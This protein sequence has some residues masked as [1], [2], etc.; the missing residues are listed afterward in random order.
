VVVLM[1]VPSVSIELVVSPDRVHR[2]EDV[3]VIARIRNVGRAA[4]SL[5]PTLLCAGLALELRSFSGERMVLGSSSRWIEASD[6]APH[7]EL[8]PGQSMSL[9]YIRPFAGR[10]PVG[11]YQVRLVS[12]GAGAGAPAFESTWV[13]F[14][15]AHLH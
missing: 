7:E 11:E 13:T 9:A 12:P 2:V 15:I 6:D 14:W 3:T 4:V 1:S 10:F 5:P 8:V